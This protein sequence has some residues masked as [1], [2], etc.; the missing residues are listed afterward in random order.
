[1]QT[2][3]ELQLANEFIR[4][5][6]SHLFLTG[7]AGTGKTTFLHKLKQASPKRMIVT[8]PTGVAAINA[9]GVTLHSFFQ[10]PFGPYLPD[11]ESQHQ[12]KQRRFRKEKV[13]II[14]SL[15]L[16]VID[17]IS[18]VRADLL[19]AVD[20]VLRRYRYKQ[21]PF[22]GVQLLM[23]GDLHQLPPVVKEDEWNLLKAH[24]DSCYFFDS[25]A[26][27]QAQMHTIE[28][29]T[30]YR[31]S[32]ARFIE[33]LNRVRDNRLDSKT[34]EQL[35]SRHTPGFKIS[36]GDDFITLTTHNRNAD[37]LNEERLQ[38]L[39]SE[40]FTFTASIEGDFPPY[41]Y[42][43]AE[44]LS[45]KKGAQVMFV[46]N[47]NS[48]DKR[49]FN[50]KIGKITRINSGGICVHC[51][52][53]VDEIV[54]DPLTWENIKYTIDEKSKQISEEVIGKF[55]QYPLRPAWAITVHKS[56]G[57]T[58]ER[59]VI[60]VNA[61]FSHGQVY[62]ALSRCKTFQGMVLSSPISL[63][64]IKT[65]VTVANFIEQTEANLPG[66]ATLHEA[67]IEY[68]Q[69][70]ILECFDFHLLGNSLGKL[71]AQLRAQRHLIQCA[72]ID[73][74]E[75][76]TPELFEQVVVVA[77]KFQQ[78]LRSLFKPDR[79]P[80]EDAHIQQRTQKACHYFSEQLHG[81]LASWMVDFKLS[82]DNKEI[83]KQITKIYRNLQH[84][85]VIKNAALESGA[86][87]F[88]T[89][90]Y[91]KAIAHAE[92]DLSPSSTKPSAERLETMQSEHPL[93][94][95]ALSTWRAQQADDEQ[96]ERY[97][98]LHQRVLIRIAEQLPGNLDRL[99][100][101]KGIG[102][103]TAKKYGEQLITMVCD[104][105]RDQ[106][107]EPLN[108]PP[109]LQKPIKKGNAKNTKQISYEAFLQGKSIQQIAKQ[110]GLVTTT[111]EGHLA[112]YVA[113]GELAVT[114]ILSAEKIANIQQAINESGGEI[115]GQIKERLGDDFSYGE[116][117]LVLASVE[118][119]AE[120]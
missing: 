71:N 46:R 119:T 27:R 19:D 57:L 93:L 94:L 92:L 59:A 106:A 7:K 72:G 16:L 48:V 4:A 31:Q 96:V 103:Q 58:F 76:M 23:I 10:L 36:D 82:T 105:C 116:I 35:N 33:L 89:A 78:Q 70:L 109:A 66:Q 108:I 75:R 88:S 11:S 90:A 85:L 30:I 87:G 104:Y 111:I 63:H 54:V 79:V 39:H 118:A 97:Q 44:T 18:M 26:L 112:H 114:R 43:T 28:L 49:Y 50:G 95:Q 67:K 21:R 81:E 60:D 13:N 120:K 51:P 80:E 15:D 47:D 62:V 69:Q 56:Q 68:Q 84:Q 77:D 91:L 64:S 40:C 107:I 99:V 2:N 37:Q 9:G 24:Y 65:D 86:N 6:G 110:R 98:I 17:E 45:L 102:E 8:A 113:R 83:K 14:K 34:L 12:T 29:K 38:A 55:T 73:A 52:D 61:A 41:S 53:D 100:N 3:P 117:K 101:I 5:T 25:Q 20:A 42:P 32:D 1:M 22:G 115:P 74:L